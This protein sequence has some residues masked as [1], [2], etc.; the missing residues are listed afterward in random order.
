MTRGG[1]LEARLSLLLCLQFAVPGAWLPVAPPYLSGA[2]GFPAWQVGGVLALA[3]LGAFA[4]PWLAGQLADRHVRAE[5][6]LGFLFLGTAAALAGVARSRSP[7]GVALGVLAQGVCFSSTISLA[8]AVALRHLPRPEA[9]YGRVRLW[10]T[11]GWIASGIAV[12]QWLL[13]RHTPAGASALVRRAQDLGRADGLWFACLLALAAACAAFALPAT[14][15]ARDGLRWNA[16]AGAWSLFRRPP[17]LG[18]FLAGLPAATIDR[19]YLYHGAARLSEFGWGPT[20]VL[21]R[22]FGVGGGGLLTLGQVAEVVTL[23][24]L[25]VLLR[26]YR[27][28]DL[29]R[30]GLAVFLVRMLALALCR[31]P[32]PVL[33]AVALHGVSYASYFFVGTLAIERVAPPDLR[34]SAQA[35]FVLVYGG[36]GSV[37][38]SLLAAAVGSWAGG[39]RGMRWEW[40]FLVPSALGVLALALFEWGWPARPAVERAR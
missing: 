2:L 17:L 29:L 11:L 28:V 24:L 25:P 36:V 30:F 38:G 19:F 12:G 26:R 5:R 4:S 14:P 10:G 18:L 27:L 3:G 1:G 6:L 32:A 34:A 31:A 8:N 7:A 13:A 23:G 40:V 39:P 9:S 21:D 16:V 33:V 20:D 37:A 15:P 35:L 22:V